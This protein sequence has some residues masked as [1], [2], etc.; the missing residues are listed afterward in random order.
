MRKFRRESTCMQHVSGLGSHHYQLLA[1][2][3][4]ELI[5]D[6]SKAVWGIDRGTS[7]FDCGIVGSHADAAMRTL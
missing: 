4:T 2:A 3:T 1:A 6:P 7:V 5:H